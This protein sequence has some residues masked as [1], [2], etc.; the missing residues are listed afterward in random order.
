[1][2]ERANIVVQGDGD[3][4]IYLYTHWD[5]SF[6]PKVLQDALLRGKSRW[7][8]SNYLT[9]I[10]FSQMIQNSVMD[11]TGYGISTCIIDNN[12]PLLVVDCATQTVFLQETIRTVRIPS[13]EVSFS[14]YVYNVTLTQENC[15]HDLN[16]FISSKHL[17]AEDLNE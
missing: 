16:N 10:I 12:Y 11:E 7:N 13:S 14:E 9:R 5:G 3:A 6:L 4:E 8:D 1:M 2:G 17:K 15:W